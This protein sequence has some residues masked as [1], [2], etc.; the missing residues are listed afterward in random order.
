MAKSLRNAQPVRERNNATLQSAVPLSRSSEH[1][2][3][4]NSMIVEKSACTNRNVPLLFNKNQSQVTKLE[5][6]VIFR[7]IQGLFWLHLYL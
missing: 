4:T 5:Q 6:S 2:Y 1:L 3:V 7:V